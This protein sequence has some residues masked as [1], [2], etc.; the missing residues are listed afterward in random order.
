MWLGV[1]EVGELV[2]FGVVE[3]EVLKGIFKVLKSYKV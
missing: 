1:L 2:G 3:V